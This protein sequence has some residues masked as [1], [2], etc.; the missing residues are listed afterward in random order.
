MSETR[1]PTLLCTANFP[2]GTG[3]AWDFIESL[4]AGVADRLASRGVRTFVSYPRL[5]AA[6][7]SLQ[8]SSAV[9][10]EHRFRPG[11]RGETT[12]A[13]DL[14]REI[15]V[16]V[17]YMADRPAWHPGYARLRRAGVSGIVVHDH[18]S[19]LRTPPSGL[20]KLAKRARMRIPGTLADTIIAVS[21]FVAHRQVETGLVPPDRVRRVWNSVPV[22]EPATPEAAAAISRSIAEELGFEPG[23]PI[24]LYV[25]RAA[26]AKGVDRAMRAFDKVGVAGRPVF[27]HAGDGP[28]LA[29]LRGLR[30]TMRRRDDIHLLGYRDDVERLIDGATFCLATSLWAEAF[31]LAALEPMARRRAVIASDAGGLGEVVVDGVTG[32]LVPPDDE[33]ALSGAMERLL[34]DVTFREG[35]AD[36]AYE[37]ARA[38]F[39]RDR[40]LD[41]LSSI[42]G[43]FFPGGRP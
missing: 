28:D 14:V 27:V 2:A 25:C 43:E 3:Y 15:G 1:A 5:D 16:D 19:G 12:G 11:S 35:L 17:V 37:R 32:M 38:E 33:P 29:R 20:R 26:E 40:Q 18:T 6:P 9:A 24:I 23:R 34:G 10:I 41:A 30:E 42:I 4:Y 36:R 22:H 8:G 31:G 39:S 7:S 21:D 13:A